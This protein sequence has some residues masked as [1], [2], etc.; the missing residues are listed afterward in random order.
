MDTGYPALIADLPDKRNETD[1]SLI[2]P[3]ANSKEPAPT[4]NSTFPI[5]TPPTIQQ[6][7]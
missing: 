6:M 2:T 4:S 7:P 1:L 5:D 3:N